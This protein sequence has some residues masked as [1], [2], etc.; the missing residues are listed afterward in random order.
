MTN[1]PTSREELA[2]TLVSEI[3]L[4][5]GEKINADPLELDI[6]SG[7][8]LSDREQR[9]AELHQKLLDQ[10]ESIRVLKASNESFFGVVDKNIDL[11]AKISS[12]E[13][14]LEKARE[15]INDLIAFARSTK[16]CYT[17]HVNQ[18]MLDRW[19]KAL[20]QLGEV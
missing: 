1:P 5:L 7:F 15:I 4:H 14:K 11:E 9:E 2:R 16:D 20:A 13:S 3:K 18:E 8:I 10:D 12:L 17:C 6:I 19:D